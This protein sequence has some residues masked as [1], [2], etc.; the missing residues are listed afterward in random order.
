NAINLLTQK[1]VDAVCYNLLQDA[2]SF[3]GNE[4][5]IT[6]ITKDTQVALG[7]SDKLTLSQKILDEAQKLSND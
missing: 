6:F 3:G 5:E 1:Q 7:R 2:T 4:N